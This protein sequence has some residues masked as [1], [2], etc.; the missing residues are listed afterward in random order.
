MKVLVCNAG[1]T[2]LKFKLYEMPEC[3]V[4]A[5]GKVERVGSCDD[6][7]FGY[8]NVSTGFKVDA[9]NQNIPDYAVGINKFLFE[10]AKGEG[11]VISDISEIERVGYKSVLSKD[12][13]G[14][15]EID[16]GV[17]QGMRDFFPLAPVHNS[18][19]IKAIETVQSVLPQAKHV[20]VFET[21]FHSD[22]PLERKLYGVPYEWYEKYGI[23]RLGYHGASH[24]Y[25]ADCLN[26]EKTEYKAISCHLGG[27]ASIC[28]IL[29]GKSVDTS[30]GMSLE[31]GLIHA[32][33][34]GD[35]DP[36]MIN[37]L[38]EIGLSDEEILQGCQ[39]KGGLLGISGVSNDLRYVM[40]AADAGNVRAKLA[41]DVFVTGIVHYIGS[42][43]IDLGGL[44]DLVFTAGIGEHSDRIR[45]MVC[46]KL[47]AIGVVL[48]EEA[49]KMN[50]AVISAPSSKVTVRVIPANE[51]LGIARRTY[52]LV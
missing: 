26:A 39:K 44:T 12:H 17:M 28:G 10:L 35:M 50:A 38:K 16:E 42:F 48:D 4:L 1:S 34:V 24:G 33:R 21:A 6:A 23:Q 37:F 22:I 43:F 8:C 11:A 13:Y 46:E 32:N 7:I 36:T 25:I 18:A 31:T 47:G 52:E 51:E 3:A 9:V 5:T 41:V 27:S 29:N 14:V 2:S 45:A 49:N 19:Y 20:G 30:F 15:H 40:E